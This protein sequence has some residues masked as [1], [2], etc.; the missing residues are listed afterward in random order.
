[1]NPLYFKIL[2]VD[3]RKAVINKFYDTL[4]DTNR[5]YNFFVDWDKVK[6]NV[7]KYKIEFNI[8]NTLIGSK[9]FDTDLKKIL[10]VYPQVVPAIPILLAI[11]NNKFKVVKDFIDDDSVTVTYDFSKRN[12]SS[13]DIDEI[14]E[15]F[16][17]TGLKKFF[18]EMSSKS[19]QDYATGV[20]VGMDTNARKNRSGSAME[21][22]LKPI[23]DDII[24]RQKSSYA[25]LFQKQFRYLEEKFNFDINSSIRNR[26]ADFII[27]KDKSKVVNIEVNFFSGSGSKPQ[28]IVDSYIERQNELR[29]NGFDFIWI[30]DGTGWKEQKN[31]IE[32]G[33]KKIDYLLNLHFVRMGLLEELLWRI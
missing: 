30:T 9:N 33:F 19:I 28:E 8:L 24:S 13:K 22:V 10:T 20:E 23:I 12:L 6:K 31:Q 2:K 1:M 16:H 14:I 27:I 21:I 4:I 25:M 7:E 26:K 17:K 15:F 18:L 3:S 32:K 11:R 5:G 29:E